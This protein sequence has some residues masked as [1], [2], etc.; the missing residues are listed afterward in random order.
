MLQANV[1]SC[2]EKKGENFG[3]GLVFR[4]ESLLIK[5]VVLIV[6]LAL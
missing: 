1:N 3:E 4:L 2:S 5:G 6:I